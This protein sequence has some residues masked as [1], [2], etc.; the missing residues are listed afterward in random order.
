MTLI[1][2]M[3][4]DHVDAIDTFLPTSCTFKFFYTDQ[5]R[6]QT[7]Y[8]GIRTLKYILNRFSLLEWDSH[9]H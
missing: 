6:I 4:I 9:F 7:E 2:V 5:E 3:A 1:D 8:H